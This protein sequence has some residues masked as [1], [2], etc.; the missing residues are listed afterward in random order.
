MDILVVGSGGR[1]HALVWKLKQSSRVRNI[2]VAPGNAGTL[3]LAKNL[4]ISKTNEIVC[5]L[6]ENK[7]DLVVVGPDNHL[8][9][10]IVDKLQELN[11][12]VFGPTKGA[13]EIEW[14]KAFAK[15]FMKMENIPTAMYEVFTDIYKAKDYIKDVSF[16]IVIKASGLALGKG[17]VIVQNIEEAKVTLD[18]IM[19][20]K[21]FGNAG[22]KVIIEEYLQG[23]EISTHA[24][25]DGDNAVMFP[26]SQDHKRIFENDRG[27]NTGGMGTIAPVPKITNEQLQEIKEKIV[28]PTL[29]G[30]KRLGKPFKGILFPGIMIT[31]NG[32]KVIEFNARFGDPETQSY[33]RILETDLID[34]LFACVNGTLNEQKINWSDK[35]SCCIVLASGGYPNNYQKGKLIAGLENIKDKDIEIFHAGTKT[36]GNNISTNGGRVFGV[37]ATGNSLHEAL[38][39]SYQA[40]EQIYFDGMQ[41]RKD[42]G[43]KSL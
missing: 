3:K 42:I 23:I 28:I 6:K 38:S 30:L 33:M 20:D 5:W 26:S 24:F 39:K 2:F 25:C 37:T 34:I 8:A 10:G 13:S 35:F 32:P 19:K 15:E 12:P 18:E 29:K 36:D 11:I 41:F 21:I 4:P 16:P 17:V 27:P 22:D 14:S 9:E 31:R 40:I 1:E 43:V 7:I